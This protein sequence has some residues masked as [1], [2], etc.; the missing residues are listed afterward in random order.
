[1]KIIKL[2][3][4]GEFTIKEIDKSL[5]IEIK[6]FLKS[7]QQTNVELLAV[8]WNVGHIVVEHEQDSKTRTE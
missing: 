3:P 8:Y 2:F 5:I 7:A 1:L 4:K 6:E